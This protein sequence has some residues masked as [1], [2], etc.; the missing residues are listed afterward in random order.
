MYK[1]WKPVRQFQGS[2]FLPPSLLLF[3]PVYLSLL[4]FQWPV[5]T[6]DTMSFLCPWLQLPC[7][8]CFPISLGIYSPRT[9]SS[10]PL[11]H[12][13]PSTSPPLMILHSLF[14]AETEAWLTQLIFGGPGYIFGKL[15]LGFLGSVPTPVPISCAWNKSH[16]IKYGCLGLSF[17]RSCRWRSISKRDGGMSGGL[18]AASRYSWRSRRLRQST[19]P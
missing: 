19:W 5:F 6:L 11:S 18:S 17:I 3:I 13:S 4:S 10:P 8:I 15:W 14:S 9:L 12:G 1:N 7:G 16:G 2:V